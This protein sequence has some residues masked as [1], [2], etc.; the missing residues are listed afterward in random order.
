M[1]GLAQYDYTNQSMLPVPRGDPGYAESQIFEIYKEKALA[2]ISVRKS[3]N[4]DTQTKKIELKY[5]HEQAQANCLCTGQGFEWLFCGLTT[6]N[7]S[8]IDLY[9]HKHGDQIAGKTHFEFTG[10]HENEV[11]SI[12][13]CNRNELLF[14]GS[15]ETGENSTEKTARIKVVNVANPMALKNEILFDFGYIETPNIYS[16]KI[17][18]GNQWIFAGAH[19]NLFVWN[20]TK[21]YNEDFVASH[22]QKLADIDP[23]AEV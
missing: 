15:G 23:S 6:G 16:L 12:A 22:H 20:F 4:L 11:C 5:I 8:V 10:V 9:S 3:G 7:I 1:K 19:K 17:D 13:L 18:N 14:S 2:K 21:L